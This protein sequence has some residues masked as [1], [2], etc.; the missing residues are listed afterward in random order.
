M[1]SS[2]EIN[3]D[4]R[5]EGQKGIKR[6]ARDLFFENLRWLDAHEAV[7]Y[8]RLPSLGALRNLVYRRQI[9]FTKLGRSL[10]FKRE[11]LDRH[12]DLLSVR[13]TSI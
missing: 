3:K 7:V 6:E 2:N 1:S 5:E 12:L 13:R 10:R 9:P 4:S 8:L 11:E